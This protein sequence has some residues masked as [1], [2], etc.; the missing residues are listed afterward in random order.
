[1][2]ARWEELA[3]IRAEARAGGQEGLMLKR[4]DAPYIGGRPMGPWFKWKR[5]PLTADCV[6]V[7]TQRGSGKRSSYYSDYT[8]AAWRDGP[9]G[10]LRR[11]A[12]LGPAQVGH[13]HALSAH[14]P[15]PLGQAGGRGR[16]G[17]DDREADRAVTP[18]GT[19]P[20]SPDSRG[21]LSAPETARI[22]VPAPACP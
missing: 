9:D 7:Y 12:A 14:Q 21:A 5:D 4:R 8:F 6:L 3:A 18:P 22:A 20:D 10:R 2:F 1:P 19:P 13:R 15:H 17:G 11:G 16:P